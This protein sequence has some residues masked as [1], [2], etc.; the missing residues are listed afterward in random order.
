V[1]PTGQT[2]AKGAV[3]QYTNEL[4]LVTQDGTRRGI[5]GLQQLPEVEILTWAMGAFGQPPPTSFESGLT[6]GKSFV[7]AKCINANN[8]K[9]HVFQA[10]AQLKLQQQKWINE[11]NT[12]ITADP[13]NDPCSV[14]PDC[15]KCITA[16]SYCGWCSVNV[17]YNGSIVGKNCAGLNT[18]ITP[19]FNCSGTFRTI[20][21]ANPTTGNTTGVTTGQTTGNPNPLFMCDPINATCIQ[22]PN[23]TLPKDVCNAQCMV[24]PIPPFLQ[25]KYFRGL[26]INMMYRP[27]EWRAHFGTNTVS[28][29]NP[30]GTVMQG[31]VTVVGQFISVTVPAGKYQ[32]LWQFQPGPAVDNLSWAWGAINQLPPTSFDQAMNTPGMTQFWYVACHDGAPTTVCDFSK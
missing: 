25:N 5:F 27:G 13:I 24:N 32:T 18:T 28:V 9:W 17:V 26:Q 29:V 20:S 21:C 14:Y 16:P 1:D 4:W 22:T 19:R 30:D 12:P 11:I 31:N 10:L 2:W 23:G 3:R 6:S 15:E 7:F 8:C